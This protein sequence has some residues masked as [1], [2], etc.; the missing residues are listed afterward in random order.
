[1]RI[2]KRAF[3]YF[4]LALLVKLAVA[5]F[6]VFGAWDPAGLIFGE[7]CFAVLVAAFYDVRRE[8]TLRLLLV[9]DAF[10]TTALVVVMIFNAQ[11]G[12]VPSVE[13]LGWAGQV[14]GVSGSVVELLRP[15]Y[16][17]FYVDLPIFW[18]VA[19]RW[20][21]F[22][23]P[24][25]STE[26]R[27][28][29]LWVVI[30]ATLVNVAVALFVPAPDFNLTAQ[31]R[32]IVNAE[33]AELVGMS[34]KTQML[35]DAGDPAGVQAAV[36]ETIGRDGSGATAATTGSARGRN[37]VIV[38]V[39]SLQ[40]LAVGREVNGQPVTPTFDAL[41]ADGQYWPNTYSQV[42]AGN[43]SDA[44][45][46]FNTSLYP[47]ESKPMAEEYGSRAFPSL[48]KL[49]KPQGYTSMTFHPNDVTFWNRD[50]LY[51]A[52]GFDE[53]YDR[54][55]FG[56]EDIIGIG[57]SDDVLFSKTLP[58]LEERYAAGQP[59]YAALVTLTGHH[60]F[61]VPEDKQQLELPADMEGTLFG[62][63]LAAMHYTDDA[64][65]RFIAGMKQSGLY[66]D[67]VIVVVGDHF[68]LQQSQMSATDL[69]LAEEMLGRPYNDADRMNV[70][71]VIVAPGALEPGVSRDPAGQVDVL[72]T[73]A[74]LLGA[75]LD[76]SV[77]FGRDLMSEQ[78]TLL[79]LRYYFPK[80]TYVD[81]TMVVIPETANVVRAYDA[82]TREPIPDVQAREAA[83]TAVRADRMGLISDSYV[84][85]LPSY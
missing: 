6:V 47:L 5:R 65:G 82:R 70:P 84:D 85:A 57:P 43:T 22:L 48:A 14:R 69:K 80:G 58:V 17:L 4:A 2:F 23:R 21:A 29:V 27:R 39:E 54:T 53:I 76:G 59:F 31:S 63:Y 75:P 12:R 32:G 74:G 3:L 9:T 51:P 61:H 55:F 40:G 62:D 8:P 81:D 34:F 41:V 60:P 83:R 67:S 15:G 56:E 79:G 26:V 33:L 28:V 24:A 52:L 78:T 66:E 35:V 73:V 49:L 44:E 30:A 42:A 11:F 68:G 50:E 16:L 36:D 71:L 45:F 64:L 25:L 13:A 38:L 46:M 7:V 18:L 19:R 10:W 77:H 20:P 37:V 1:M 72:P